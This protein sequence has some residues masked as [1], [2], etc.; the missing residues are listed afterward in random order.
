MKKDITEEDILEKFFFLLGEPYF[1]IILEDMEKNGEPQEVID[2]LR[3]LSQ[4]DQ[5]QM[6]A[7]CKRWGR[8][9]EHWLQEDLKKAKE[10]AKKAEEKLKLEK[11][12]MKKPKKNKSI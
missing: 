7:E 2:K 8:L 9:K 12:K 4:D 3:K 6:L 5:G 1:K 10:E 11:K